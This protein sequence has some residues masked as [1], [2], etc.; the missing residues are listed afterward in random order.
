M[1][2]TPAAPDERSIVSRTPE[3]PAASALIE[4]GPPLRHRLLASFRY[5]FSTE[6][7]VYAM[8]IAANILL[9]FIPFA[10]LL[11]TFSRNVLHSQAVTDALLALVRDALPSNHEFITRNLLIVAASRKAQALALAMLLFSASGVLLPLE[12]A[13]NRLWGLPKNRSYIRNQAVS[14]GLAVSCSLLSLAAVLLTAVNMHAISSSF[15][16]LGLTKLAGVATYIALKA[17]TLPAI[18][19]IF[20]LIYYFLPNGK[21]PV[22]RVLLSAVM[23]G[24]LS[25]AAKHIFIWAL[26]LLKFRDVYGPFYVSVTLLMYAFFSAM[27]LLTGAHFA[28]QGAVRRADTE[29]ENMHRVAANS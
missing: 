16:R 20:F 15:G 26:P 29:K 9:S 5:A 7:H 13:L 21:V 14:Y 10:V 27:V 6:V 12:V 11:L 22:R 25:E 8:A 1:S 19:L 18:V 23:A 2:I 24:V 28:A 4:S 3:H 17:A